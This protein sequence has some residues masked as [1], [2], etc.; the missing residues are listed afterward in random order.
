MTKDGSKDGVDSVVLHV[1]GTT[2]ARMAL[3]PRWVQNLI[4]SIFCRRAFALFVH[5]RSFLCDEWPLNDRA[6]LKGHFLYDCVFG[7]NLRKLLGPKQDLSGK[8]EGVVVEDTTSPL[9]VAIGLP[10]A[11][12]LLELR[13]LAV[14]VDTAYAGAR[15]RPG[16]DYFGR[17]SLFL[18]HCRFKTAVAATTTTSKISAATT[19]N[20]AVGSGNKMAP[21]GST[22]PDTG[23]AAA[24]AALPVSGDVLLPSNNANDAVDGSGLPDVDVDVDGTEEPGSPNEKLILETAKQEAAKL[25][26][27]HVLIEHVRPAVRAKRRDKLEGSV[28][29]GSAG[30]SREWRDNRP[31]KR[32]REAEEL[33]RRD[34]NISTE[35]TLCN[36]YEISIC[37]VGEG[38]AEG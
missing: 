34:G 5:S 2:A 10:A 25:E 24:A 27:D 32:Q 30:E 15:V 6:L 26:K 37:P 1:R 11:D 35:M 7:R 28:P 9:A 38:G 33:L 19:T 13:K 29:G 4:F 18:P 36:F 20:G 21:L 23:N 14:S 17:Y 16:P 8:E 31:E 12:S 3:I 22:S